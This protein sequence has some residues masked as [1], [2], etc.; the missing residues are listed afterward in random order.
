ME[1]ITPQ[2]LFERLRAGGPNPPA[3][4]DVREPGEHEF[5]ALPGSRL[6][7]LGEL[8]DRVGEL[9]DWRDRDIVVYCHHGIRSARGAGLLRQLGFTRLF[10]LSGGVDRWTQEV[11]PTFPR[12]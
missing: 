2:A 9:E 6:I 7:P 10:N 4:L 11:D 12:Y 5:C 8:A 1:S 3:L